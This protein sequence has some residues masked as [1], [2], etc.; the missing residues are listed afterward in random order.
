MLKLTSENFDEEVLNSDKPVLVDFWASW[1]PPCRALAPIVHK[2][3][4]DYIE[5]VKIAS[6][7]TDENPDISHSYSITA[8][9]TLVFFENG[10]PIK[11][12]TGMQSER[13]LR[14]HLDNL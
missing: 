8:L 2:L 11:K 4:V 1:C 5:T 9:P 6:L 10:K 14:E 13:V 3:A 12:I 7:N